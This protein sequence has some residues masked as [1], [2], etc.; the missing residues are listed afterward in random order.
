MQTSSM[1][2]YK[3]EMLPVSKSMKR[4]KAA[5]EAAGIEQNIFEMEESTRTAQDAA[6]ACK[7]DVGQ[8]V[9]SLIFEGEESGELVLL[10]VSGAHNVDM[11][12]VKA[13]TGEGLGRA[14][15][16]RVRDVTGFA[17]GGVSPVG[18]LSPIRAFLDPRLFDFD[19]IWAA[20]GTPHHVFS[21]KPSDLERISAAQAS[22]FTS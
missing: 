20:A 8:I 21:A 3:K 7:C 19:I 4:V 18:H 16:K 11:E 22:D 12:K 9:K 10:L 14:D 1:W 5:L 17:I 15:P 2:F 13:V 6:I